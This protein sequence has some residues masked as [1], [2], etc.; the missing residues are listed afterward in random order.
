MAITT[1]NVTGGD[2]YI[3]MGQY[4]ADVVDALAGN[5]TIIGHD[6]ADLLLG[7]LGNDLILAGS[8]DTDLD[9]MSGG[10]GQDT[11]YG[12]GG[13]DLLDGGA[14]DDVM[15]GGTGNDLM[16]GDS[17]VRSFDLYSQD[18]THYGSSTSL[19]DM[20]GLGNALGIDDNYLNSF[21]QSASGNDTMWGGSGRDMMF[22]GWGNDVMGGGFGDDL[23][24]GNRGDDVIFGGKSGNDVLLGGDENDTIFGGNGNDII[25]AD[26]TPL[27]YDPEYTESYVNNGIYWPGIDN[28]PLN[29]VRFLEEEQIEW[30]SNDDNH[31]GH[32]LVFGGDGDDLIWG[33]EGMDTIWGGS[34]NDT[35]LPGDDNDTDVIGF[36]AGHGED[37]IYGFD[38]GEWSEGGNDAWENGEDVIYL[39]GASYDG[40][41]SDAVADGTI[42]FDALNQT[43]T[44]NTDG[45]GLDGKIT[46]HFEI[47]DPAVDDLNGNGLNDDYET[48]GAGN[49]AFADQDN[50]APNWVDFTA[51]YQFMV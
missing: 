43:V 2:D 45:F 11:I 48:F 25:D 29:L 18:W 13:G 10:D 17:G 47:D 24:V 27:P 9:V 7:N 15:G 34:G 4:S 46:I 21:S 35:I 33:R 6:G 12:G 44:I 30:V 19:L 16:F 38:A 14:G 28:S 23:V 40:E 20:L 5:D 26:E 32:D 36:T 50:T 41:F 49:I 8:T 42:V 39:E 37:V 3:E 22:G 51:N 31:N 1:T